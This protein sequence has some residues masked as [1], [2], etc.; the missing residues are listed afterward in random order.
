[1]PMKPAEFRQAGAA[2]TE[3]V[4]QAIRSANIRAE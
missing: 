3:R 2:E 4:G 1:M